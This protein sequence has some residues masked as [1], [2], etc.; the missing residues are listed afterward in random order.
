M[1]YKYILSDITMGISGRPKDEEIASGLRVELMGMKDGEKS[2][3]IYTCA[4][5]MNNLTGL[6]LAIGALVL[7]KGE[8]QTKGV[9]APEG[10]IDPDEFLSE[11]GKRGIR[12]FEGEEME[13]QIN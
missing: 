12:I 10:C 3:I 7:G 9:L 4:D 2:Q 11:L 8:I 1:I 5:H 13:R 6:P